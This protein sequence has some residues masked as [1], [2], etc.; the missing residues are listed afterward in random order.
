MNVE[1]LLAK[2]HVVSTLFATNSRRR[3]KAIRI[4]HYPT[5]AMITPRAEA[6]KNSERGEISV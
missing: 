5:H 2:A 4:E 1:H 6:D 3:K